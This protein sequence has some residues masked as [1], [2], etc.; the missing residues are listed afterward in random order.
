MNE[1]TKFPISLN[2]KSE[3]KGNPENL[4]DSILNE[5]LKSR[6]IRNVGNIIKWDQQ[7]VPVY[8]VKEE[9]EG[10]IQTKEVK[11]YEVKRIDVVFKVMSNLP[12]EELV[13]AILR[14]SIKY[15]NKEDSI[16]YKDH[17]LSIFNRAKKMK[18][19]DWNVVGNIALDV[20]KG[21]ETISSFG[22]SEVYAIFSPKLYSMLYRVVDKTGTLELELVKECCR[23]LVSPVVE[24]IAL[25]SKRGFYIYEKDYPKIE[26]LGREGVY[27]VYM[28]TG[29]LAPYLVDENAGVVI[30]P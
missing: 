1:E 4:M 12:K 16:L 14:A 10:L 19:S 26:Y 21:Y 7:S 18:A 30:Q 28:I 15:S 29:A 3:A 9:G 23:V 2:E 20:I 17:P 25:V 22:Y 27:D 8:E 13:N 24:S 6:I 5:T 11:L